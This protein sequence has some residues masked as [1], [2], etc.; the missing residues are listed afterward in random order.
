M[1]VKLS[2]TLIVF[3]RRDPPFI[4]SADIAGW[5]TISCGLV[6]H[7]L[8]FLTIQ[9]VKW[10]DNVIQGLPFVIAEVV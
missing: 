9:V 1:L 7:V 2:I 6:G 3:K 8:T 10:C 5:I 4:Y